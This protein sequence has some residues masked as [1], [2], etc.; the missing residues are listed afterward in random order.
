LPRADIAGVA[1]NGANISD[2]GAYEVQNKFVVTVANGPAGFA[3]V[4]GVLEGLDDLVKT[5][6]HVLSAS[7]QR[8]RAS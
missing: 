3:Q 8:D 2:L 1:P 4:C 5:V 6:H 7:S